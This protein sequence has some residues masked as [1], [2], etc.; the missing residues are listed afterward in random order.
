M[1]AYLKNKVR[2]PYLFH[3][4][5]KRSNIW[6]YTWP[7]QPR[8]RGSSSLKQAPFPLSQLCSDWLLRANTKFKVGG[9]TR[10]KNIKP[11]V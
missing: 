6:L 10:E 7:V 2:W 5:K 11:S 1:S 4:R 8:M 9:A 3:I